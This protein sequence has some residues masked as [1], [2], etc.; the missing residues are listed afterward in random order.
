MLIAVK[1]IWFR[2]ISIS[3]GGEGE[4][5]CVVLQRYFGIVPRVLAR[6]VESQNLALGKIK[7]VSEC[8]IFTFKSMIKDVRLLHINFI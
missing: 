8:Q 4:G 1:K 3:L 2:E 7:L 5:E 6:V